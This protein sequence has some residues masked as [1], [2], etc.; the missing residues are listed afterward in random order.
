MS[1]SITPLTK[2]FRENNIPKSPLVKLRSRNTGTYGNVVW[3]QVKDGYTW[4][5]TR[6]HYIVHF[7]VRGREVYDNIIKALEENGVDI[8]S[9]HHNFEYGGYLSIDLRQ[10]TT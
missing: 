3:G 6:G 4:S 8:K 9:N 1:Y 2:I 10:F 7:E 5:K